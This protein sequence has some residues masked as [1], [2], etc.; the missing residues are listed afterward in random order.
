MPLALVLILF[1]RIDGFVMIWK[2]VSDTCEEGGQVP[3]GVDEDSYE[4]NRETWSNCCSL[5][6]HTSDVY[7]LSWLPD[8]VHLL[9]GS[10]DKTVRLWNVTKARLV[11][12]F[13]EHNNFV[14]GVAADPLGRIL[15]SQSCDRTVRLRHR[16]KAS[17]RRQVK[18]K[19]GSLE[20]QDAQSHTHT[21]SPSTPN[22]SQVGAEEGSEGEEGV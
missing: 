17:S 6:G 16:K 8:S 14:Q 21:A 2:F 9:S 13:S 18:S 7:D 12:Q 19:E 5:R 22:N 3:F 20:E 10:M 1:V 4:A 15:A 11:Q